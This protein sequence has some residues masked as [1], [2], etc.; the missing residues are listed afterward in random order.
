MGAATID[1]TWPEMAIVD[2]PENNPPSAAPGHYLRSARPH[3]RLT[4]L[5]PANMDGIDTGAVALGL[6][7][8]LVLFD[9]SEAAYVVRTQGET[10]FIACDTT[11]FR[12]IVQSTN[13]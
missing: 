6:D 13:E 4:I 2:A 5:E 10:A 11:H 9:A 8:R 1:A 3:P 12:W 7:R